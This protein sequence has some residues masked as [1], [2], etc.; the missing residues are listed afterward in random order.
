MHK[1]ILLAALGAA[2]AGPALAADYHRWVDDNGTVHFGTR[3]PANQPSTTVTTR[4]A[5]PVT[6]P[7]AAASAAATTEEAPGAAATPPPAQPLDASTCAQLRGH[8]ETLRNKP[9]VR[10]VDPDTGE[11]VTLDAERRAAMTQQISEQLQ[12]CP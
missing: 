11:H 5:P 3:P 6:T 2:L 8:L 12:R 1:T 10:E 9:I 7:A 4:P